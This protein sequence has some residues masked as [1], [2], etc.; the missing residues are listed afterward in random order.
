M[1][2]G[3]SSPWYAS[4]SEELRSAK[5][6][7]RR[8]ERKW[9][10]TGLTVD[11]QIYSEAKR[12]VTNIVHKAKTNY[13]SSKIAQ[14]S[15]CKELF[16]V[17]DKLGGCKSDSPLPTTIPTCELP[18]AFADYFIQK[19]KTIRSELGSQM[20]ML[21]LPTDNPYTAS[22]FCS[23]QP[24]SIQHNKNTILKSSQKTCSLDPI[25]TFL[26]VK[27]LDRLLPAMTAI[28]NKSLQTG[29]FSSV[30]K[31]AIVMPL[32][33]KHHLTRTI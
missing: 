6:L 32:L 13:F 26:F 20:P 4:V 16:S 8:A 9:L 23:F 7:R 25:P 28:I 24:V 12:A 1:P 15:C 33:K 3:W 18:D 22:S 29:V 10:K 2:A 30:F 11:K 5:R 14:S 31:A 17:C 21:N 27:C 19:V